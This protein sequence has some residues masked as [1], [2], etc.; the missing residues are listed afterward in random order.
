MGKVKPGRFFLFLDFQNMPGTMR[1]S[2]PRPQ[3]FGAMR[4][5]SQMPRMMSTQRVGQSLMKWKKSC[6]NVNVN[7]LPVLYH[8]FNILSFWL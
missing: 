3:T 6:C 4:P 7:E 2:A 8:Y 5:A 1:P